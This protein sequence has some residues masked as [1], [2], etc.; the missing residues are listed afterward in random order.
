MLASGRAIPQGILPADLSAL[1]E[2]APTAG[3]GGSGLSCPNR[4]KFAFGRARLCRPD[5]LQRMD[6]RNRL[7]WQERAEAGRDDAA[8]LRFV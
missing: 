2:K 4:Q 5:P 7:G 8:A 6:A 3:L 1:E